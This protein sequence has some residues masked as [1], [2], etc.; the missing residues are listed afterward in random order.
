MI[1]V[2]FLEES[3]QIGGAEVNVL[4][5]VKRLDPSS[6]DTVVICP[7][8]G[9]FTTKVREVG[10]KVALVRR[11]PLFS[12][13]VL[14]RG[15]KIS[16]PLAM[17]GNF[18]SFFISAWLLARYLRRERV[19]ILHTNSMLTHFYG[20]LAARL[21]GVP[22]LWHV[23]D[24]VDEHQFFGILKRALNSCGRL[25]PQRIV[26]V[27]K[28]VADMF[29][30]PARCKVRVIYNGTEVVSHSSNGT[31][32]RIR[33]ELGIDLQDPVVGIVG[34]IVHWKGHQDFLRAARQVYRQI[35]RCRFLVVGDTS[36]GSRIYER[37]IRK[38][39]TKLGLERVVIF[40]GFRVDVP[41]LIATMDVVVNASELPEPFGL[42]VVEAMAGS[43]PVVATNGGG[44]SE[45]VVNGVTGTL[46]PMKDVIALERAIVDLLQAPKKRLTMG[47]AGKRRVEKLFT[48][49]RFVQEMS[50]EYLELNRNPV[51]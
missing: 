44:I 38:L 9:L 24:I 23:Q 1:K 42:S 35:P 8:E 40:T 18:V 37:R 34:R 26:V 22:C 7:F 25:F 33:N 45:I 27:S 48:L 11:A 32:E 19:D 5:L 49:D 30:P 31:G 28:S 43:K 14:L 3:A 10:G 29:D 16:N 2:G 6:I 46:V 13:S 15:K 47:L 50:Q 4:N 41:D 12:T 39:V 20:A 51:R 21:V 36:F 17:M